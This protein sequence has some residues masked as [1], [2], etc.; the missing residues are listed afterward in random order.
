M[1]YSLHQIA[2]AAQS[3]F[4][5]IEKSLTGIDALNKAQALDLS[6]FQPSGSF[7]TD[8]TPLKTSAGACFI[9]EK[10][11]HLLP[12]TTTPLVTPT[13]KLFFLRAARLFQKEAFDQGAIEATARIHHDAFVHPTASIGAYVIIEKGVTIGP[14]CRIEP[15]TVIAQG[16]T[17][18]EGC[19]I[20]SHVTLS[21]ATLGVRVVI[22]PGTRIGQTGFGFIQDGK[23][24]LD[25]PHLGQ[26][27]IHDHVHIGANC[28]IDRGNFSDTVLHTHARLDNGIHIAHNVSIGAHS[29]LA[30]QCGIAGSVDIGAGCILGGQVGVRDHVVLGAQTL[31]AAQS[32]I[33][34]ST[35]KGEKIGGSPALP[36]QEWHRAHIFLKN[37]VRQKKTKE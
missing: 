9:E 22:G 25:V 27:H 28:T 24:I 14:R 6:F 26:V 3:T 20:G 21:H 23:D 29:I 35:L 4:N 34:R 12:E 11:K 7:S 36:I 5:G 30:A 15:M 17:M 37:A 19:H 1:S 2:H 31:V 18:Q 16:V 32:G 13:P 10:Y 8:N 33:A